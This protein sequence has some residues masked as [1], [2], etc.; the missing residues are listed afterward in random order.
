MKLAICL[1]VCSAMAGSALGQ[2][3]AVS[4]S[5]SHQSLP[6]KFPSYKHGH[7]DFFV[8]IWRHTREHIRDRLYSP[9]KHSSVELLPIHRRRRFGF[10]KTICRKDCLDA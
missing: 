1:V 10:K 4:D 5:D 6:E 3:R 9:D 7:Q 2:W 8:S